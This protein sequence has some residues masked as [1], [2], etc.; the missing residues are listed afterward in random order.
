MK[1]LTNGQ[2]IMR[3]TTVTILVTQK[4]KLNIPIVA[5][6]PQGSHMLVARAEATSTTRIAIA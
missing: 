2:R 6:S 1:I 4:I 3:R 5:L